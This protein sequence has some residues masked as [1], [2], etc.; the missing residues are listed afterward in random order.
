M[1]AMQITS[2]T[3]ALQFISNRQTIKANKTITTQISSAVISNGNHSSAPVKSSI[4]TQAY[5]SN[6]SAA[7]RPSSSI[8]S[9]RRSS[10][11]NGSI[12]TNNIVVPK[13]PIPSSIKNV[14]QQKEVDRKSS[15]SSVSNISSNSR[16]SSESNGS[17][18]IN[19]V[20]TNSDSTKSNS[21]QKNDINST[22]NPPSG[23]IKHS[24]SNGH[25]NGKSQTT[26]PENNKNNGF[27]NGL[28]QIAQIN[29]SVILSSNKQPSSERAINENVPES[30][31]NLNGAISSNKSSTMRWADLFPKGETP[32]PAIKYFASFVRY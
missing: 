8:S 18:A 15:T 24:T 20:D 10:I 11:S 3:T 9:S 6:E 4:T 28:T 13:E 12:A 5:L 25:I 16:R 26:V 14:V 1:K 21:K 27:N 29:D 31:P 2:P 32:K 30:Q 22:I 23:I 7:N 17:K 19:S